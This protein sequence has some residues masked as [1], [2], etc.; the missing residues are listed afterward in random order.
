MGAALDLVREFFDAF[1]V[2]DIDR[3]DAVFDDG[4]AFVMPMGP[5]TKPEH[6]MMGMSFKA[7]LP[8]SH[9]EIDHA[10]DNGDEVFIE[11]RFVGTHTG[12]LPGPDGSSLPASGNK[13]ELRFADYFKARDGKIVEHRTYFDQ[14][15]MMGQLTGA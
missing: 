13:L 11:G 7:G 9:M 12:D 14:A 3:A 4:C 2:D 10:V 8:D 1:A 5:M 6:R 15:T